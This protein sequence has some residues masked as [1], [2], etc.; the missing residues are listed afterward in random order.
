M[1]LCTQLEREIR[2]LRKD[3][4]RCVIGA[5]LN[6]NP[7]SPTNPF[8]VDVASPARKKNRDRFTQRIR[9]VRRALE[10]SCTFVHQGD[11]LTNY[12][13]HAVRV[14]EYRQFIQALD[15]V[16]YDKRTR[17]VPGSF[18]HYLQ[19]VHTAPSPP[20]FG[21]LQFLR[22]DFDHVPLLMKI[23]PTDDAVA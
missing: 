11:L 2:A 13:Y 4:Y 12:N 9:S 10:R 16:L 18:R 20:T 17:L 22:N 8:A 6:V 7:F 5:D 15:Y 21:E 14:G 1:S 23:A 19:C 3:G